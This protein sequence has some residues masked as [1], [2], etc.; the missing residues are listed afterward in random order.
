MPAI[1]LAWWLTHCKHEMYFVLLLINLRIGTSFGGRL[2]GGNLC[3]QC[4]KEEGK[5]L[6]QGRSRSSPGFQEGQIL[7]THG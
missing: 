4:L 2:Q 1:Y 7:S 3:L 5:V 6:G